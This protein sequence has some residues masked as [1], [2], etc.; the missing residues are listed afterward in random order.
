MRQSSHPLLPVRVPPFPQHTVSSGLIFAS[1][2]GFSF[3]SSIITALNLDVPFFFELGLH[4]GGPPAPPPTVFPLPNNNDSQYFKP[5]ARKPPDYNIAAQMAARH[6]QSK[7]KLGRSRAHSHDGVGMS[8][9]VDGAD[10][11]D[12]LYELSKL[13]EELENFS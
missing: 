5:R 1:Y 4:H 8:Y 9:F 3:L 10:L 11:D 6:R 13:I 7:V 2:F 12:G